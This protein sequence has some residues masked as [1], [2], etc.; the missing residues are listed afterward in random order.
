MA[1]CRRTTKTC[2][3]ISGCARAGRPKR[4]IQCGLELGHPTLG[5]RG[6]GVPTEDIDHS[7][8][9]ASLRSFDRSGPGR[10][11]VVR[12]ELCD[13]SSARGGA[14]DV[15]DLISSRDRMQIRS[16]RC[17]TGGTSG[18]ACCLGDRLLRSTVRVER[19]DAL[20]FGARR[21]VHE[22]PSGVNGKAWPRIIWMHVLEGR[23]DPL[24]SLGNEPSHYAQFVHGQFE[25]TLHNRHELSSPPTYSRRLQ[26]LDRVNP[27]TQDP[28]F[29]TQLVV[30]LQVHPELLG[31]AE[32]ARQTDRRVSRDS[33]LAVDDLVDPTRP[34]AIRSS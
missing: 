28:P 24:S 16:G 27:V 7:G 13:A 21:A 20:A 22:L 11:I 32:V 5:S 9:S 4:G 15:P 18:E 30:R 8:S 12:L 2:A 10:G 3:A 1:L 33:S 26:R 34:A 17:I 31:R 23:Q 14:Q 29:A 25:V 19:C 6:N